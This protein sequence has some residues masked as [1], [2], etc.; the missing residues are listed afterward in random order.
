MVAD[1]PKIV[2]ECCHWM[3]YALKATK[4]A[5][6]GIEDGLIE[7]ALGQSGPNNDLVFKSILYCPFCGT[8]IPYPARGTEVLQ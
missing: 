2:G 8:K 4:E 6:F 7:I 5:S 1:N 3:R